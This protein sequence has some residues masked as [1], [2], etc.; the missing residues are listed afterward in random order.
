MCECKP[1]FTQNRKSRQQTNKETNSQQWSGGGYSGM[2]LIVT[3]WRRR[4]KMKTQ[5]GYS[6]YFF[7]FKDLYYALGVSLERMTGWQ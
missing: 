1:D 6:I 5:I 7:F 4:R 2:T 3:L